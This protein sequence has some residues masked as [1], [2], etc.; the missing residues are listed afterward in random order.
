MFP[1]KGHGEKMER[2][3]VFILMIT[4]AGCGFHYRGKVDLSSTVSSIWV[5]GENQE[6]VSD[7]RLALQ[8]SGT[9]VVNDPSKALLI[10]DI[11]QVQYV[12]LVKSVDSKGTATGYTLSYTIVYRAM[13]KN[14]RV[15]INDTQLVFSRDLPYSSNQ[16][17][18]KREEEKLL[19][20]SMRM[21][22]VRRIIRRLTL[23][24][25]NLDSAASEMVRIA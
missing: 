4:V 24:T 7:L 2:I 6:L 16:L 3:V 5:S 20:S 19:K 12:K 1:T 25:Q 21:E 14:G 17:L 15:I 13:D 18:Q 11:L 9:N 22:A 8:H 10:I 23:L